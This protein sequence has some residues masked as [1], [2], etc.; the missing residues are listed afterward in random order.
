M[1][2]RAAIIR[3]ELTCMGDWNKKSLPEFVGRSFESCRIRFANGRNW[4]TFRKLTSRKEVFRRRGSVTFVA[5][6]FLDG[7]LC[8]TPA[9]SNAVENLHSPQH[10]DD[11]RQ[12]AGR[13][14]YFQGSDSHTDTP[15]PSPTNGLVDSIRP[16]QSRGRRRCK[17]AQRCGL[18]ATSLP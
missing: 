8:S 18:R 3:Y 13:R 17:T 15:L 9:R 11:G 6:L 2:T 16:P 1:S 12:Q 4:L 5:N 14:Q 7:G 10:D